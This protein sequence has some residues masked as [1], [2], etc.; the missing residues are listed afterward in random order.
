MAMKKYFISHQFI[1]DDNVVFIKVHIESIGENILIYFPSKYNVP[2]EYEVTSSTEITPYELTDKDLL[3]SQK[4]Q[5]ADVTDYGELNIDSI[6]DIN[7]FNDD[8]YH[9]INI[10]SNRDSVIRKKLVCYSNQ[11]TRMKNCTAKI[12]YKFAILTD[13]ILSII[14]RYN[15]VETYLIKN[16]KGLVP[17]IVDSKTDTIIPIE[18]QLYVLIDLPSFYEKINQIP[19][20]II[21]LYRNFYGTLSNTHTKQTSMAEHQF[22][23]YQQIISR[24]VGE[25]NKKNQMLDL[26]T[27]L[28][29]SLEK[30]KAQETA[31]L[32][33]IAI[34]ESKRDS[35]MTKDTDRSFKLSKG[36]Q[37][38]QKIGD[39]RKKI[40]ETLHEV[41]AKYH[42][43]RLTYD[44]V[45]TETT[46]DL[47]NT[48]ANMALLG[49]TL[50]TGKKKK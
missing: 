34:V 12:K 30:S 24:M 7:A 14:N 33:K 41:K 35:S 18:H 10:D 45:I 48:E 19:D 37:E 29:E 47:K 2:R 31:L 5:A 22:K 23:N 50:E 38:L 42:N 11:L 39:L 4:S 36:Q 15:E 9:Q 27:S 43:Y 46:R 8:N 20:D 26:M 32:E 28:T 21:K 44:N 13:E 3:I 16:G 40:R 1:V 17:N 25:Y 6:K 49:I